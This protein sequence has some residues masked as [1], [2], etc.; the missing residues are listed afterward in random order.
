[1]SLSTHNLL[2]NHHS[3]SSFYLKTPSLHHSST[4]IHFSNPPLFQFSNYQVPYKSLSTFYSPIRAFESDNVKIYDNQENNT[5]NLDFDA[6]LSIAEFV[7]LV[8]SAVISLGIFLKPLKC[9]LVWLGD[10]AP[11]CQF[12]LLGAGILIG[13]VIRR[14]QWRRVCMGFSKPGRVEVN[15]VDRI[16]KL[17]EDIRSWGNVVRVMSKQLEKLGI[18]FRVTRRTLRD[19]IAEAADL[20]RKNSEATRELAMKEE[21][22]ENELG[23]IQKV[24]LAMQ[25]QQQKQLELILA[26]AKHGN[27]LESRKA[28]SRDPP[29]SAKETHK[30]AV[31]RIKQMS[32]NQNEA[33]AGQ[34]DISNESAEFERLIITNGENS[35]IHGFPESQVLAPH[36]HCTFAHRQT[37]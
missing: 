32:T 16:E 14:R 26:I 6:F 1:M 33:L 29:D 7:C 9:I 28:P 18:R 13:S 30:P 3:H 12:L 15:V 17:E 31:K 23:E 21:I 25:E 20:A 35:K 27:L 4:F 10:K 11:V 8:S 22:L 2:K 36:V 5:R 37:E 34:K 24:L 19:P